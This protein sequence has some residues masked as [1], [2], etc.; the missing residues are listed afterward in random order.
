MILNQ[1]Q[2]D[3]TFQSGSETLSGRFVL[4]SKNAQPQLLFLHGA[5]QSTKE[6]ALPLAERL[7]KNFGI[8]SFLFDFSGH[9]KSTGELSESSLSKR[10]EE[11]SSAIDF[12]GLIEPISI[13]AFSMGG[14]IALELLGK[15]SVKNI[16][17][18]YSAVYS[19]EAFDFMFGDPK[20]SEILRTDGSWKKS[21]VWDFL[22]DFS[23]NLLV[24]TGEKDSV[25]PNEIP[26]L[27]VLKANKA[28]S[29]E[30]IVLPNAPHLLLPIIYESDE[31]ME[32]FCTKIADLVL[33][34]S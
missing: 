19:S 10:V 20:F 1:D 29:K 9:G 16:M 28:A 17:L 27:L 6:R 18:F 23:G 34:N 32:R 3:V 14:H 7:V 12:A 30:L 8:S 5:G 25:V 24:V 11:A 31:L 13:C 22:R 21:K 26:R 2:T 4:N 33:R 15:K